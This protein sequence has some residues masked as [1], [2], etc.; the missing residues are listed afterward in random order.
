MPLKNLARCRAPSM[1]ERYWNRF[2][3][4]KRAGRRPELKRN[5]VEI[6]LRMKNMNFWICCTPPLQNPWFWIPRGVNMQ[7]PWR[8]ETIFMALRN[9]DRRAMPVR[10]LLETFLH[11]EAPRGERWL[12]PWDPMGRRHLYIDTHHWHMLLNRSLTSDK[13]MFLWLDLNPLTVWPNSL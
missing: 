6:F 3:S 4:P 8:P 12:P 1:G 9:L 10:A 13:P 11:L 2:W 5:Q 7:P